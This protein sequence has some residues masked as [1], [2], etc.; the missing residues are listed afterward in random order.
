LRIRTVLLVILAV[1]AATWVL[2]KLERVRLAL[3]VAAFFAYVAIPMPTLTAQLGEAVSQAPASA[4]SFRAQ[5]Q[6]WSRS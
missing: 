4:D 6:G 3:T 1:G 2:Y 5:A